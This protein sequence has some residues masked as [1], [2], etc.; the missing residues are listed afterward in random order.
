MNNKTLTFG[1]KAELISELLSGIKLIDENGYI[2][3]YDENLTEPLRVRKMD[4]EK[5]Y[6]IFKL[7]NHVTSVEFTIYQPE[8]VYETRWQMMRDG[9]DGVTQSTNSFYSEQAAEENML[10]PDNGWYRGNSVKVRIS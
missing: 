10:T 4:E 7:W 5:N 1:T 6:P 8:P 3:F 9:K 2:Y